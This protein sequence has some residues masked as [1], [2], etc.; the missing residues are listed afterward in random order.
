MADFIEPENACAWNAFDAKQFGFDELQGM[1]QALKRVGTERVKNP[2]R[3]G[4]ACESN[5]ATPVETRYRWN[6]LNGRSDLNSKGAPALRRFH[7]KP[8]FSD[9]ACECLWDRWELRH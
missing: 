4:S 9:H 5:R 6:V 8:S 1:N 2:A 7:A 3:C